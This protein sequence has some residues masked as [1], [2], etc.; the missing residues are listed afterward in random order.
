MALNYQNLDDR[1]R[2]YMIEEIELAVGDG[3]IYLSP[4]LTEKGIADWPEMLRAAAQ[5]GSDAT[6]A[7][8]ISRNGRLREMALR[9]KPKSEEM[10]SYKVPVTA[11]NTMAEGEFNRFY[12][13]ALC[14]RAISDGIP[15]LIVYRAKAVDVPRPGSEEKIGT[16]IDP[17]P[18]LEDLRTS[19]GV[20]PS[21][22]L[23]PGPNSGLTVRL[24]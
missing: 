4:W 16:A 13:R 12:V 7:A 21:L 8:E 20:E 11:P 17:A 14:R 23:P 10:V 2:K 9:R 19:P 18:L 1:T 24:P 15:H 6:L 3:S 22:G 5:N